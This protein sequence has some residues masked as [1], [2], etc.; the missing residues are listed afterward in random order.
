LACYLTAI[1]R[2]INCSLLSHARYVDL[3]YDLF[4]NDYDLSTLCIA[5]GC[6]AL[7]AEVAIVGGRS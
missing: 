4:T 2:S 5:L 1:D 7:G 3:G 6:S